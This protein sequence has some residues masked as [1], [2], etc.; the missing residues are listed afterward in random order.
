MKREKRHKKKKVLIVVAHPDDET[1]W[2]GGTL[3]MN[4]NKWDTKII[5]LCRKNDKDRAPK[6]RKICKIL[7]AKCHI[8]NLEDEK[9]D[10]V[11]IEEIIKII[12]KF[13]PNKSYDYIFT[14]GENGEYGHIRHKET[15]EAIRK[16]LKEKVLLCKR[17]LFFSYIK[18]G[19]YCRAKKNADK[20]IKLKDNFLLE[21]KNLIHNIYGFEKKS[22]EVKS[23]GKF[24]TFNLGK[25]Q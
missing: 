17:I 4:K 13:T 19:T 6:F 23:S 1:I 7:K 18:R 24:E 2:M 16:M 8:A 10:R 20:F 15:N 12:K 21:K 9:L 22:F 3:L 5:S 14:H 25:K 11:S